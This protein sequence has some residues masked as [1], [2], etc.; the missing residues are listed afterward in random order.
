MPGLFFEMDDFAS[1]CSPGWI[2]PEPFH[3]GFEEIDIA[4]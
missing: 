1:L 3:R 2:I 4:I